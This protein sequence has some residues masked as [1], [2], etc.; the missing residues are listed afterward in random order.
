LKK[1]KTL[2]LGSKLAVAEG[3][4]VN[5]DEGVDGREASMPITNPCDSITVSEG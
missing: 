1:G 4:D 5:V 3:E 2:T